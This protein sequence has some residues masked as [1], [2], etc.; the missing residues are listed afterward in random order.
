MTDEEELGVLTPLIEALAR[1]ALRR[2]QAAEA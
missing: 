1:L 2:L